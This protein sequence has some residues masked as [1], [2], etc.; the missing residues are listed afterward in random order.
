MGVHRITT[1]DI[2]HMKSEEEILKEA[3]N[4][5][6]IPT[7]KIV[8]TESVEETPFTIIQQEEEGEHDIL[9]G[10]YRMASFNTH[11]EAYEWCKKMTWTQIMQVMQALI[12]ENEWN[13][14]NIGA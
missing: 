9:M 1:N 3:R 5:E 4:V 11:T 6:E 2:K 12:Q 8:Y 10:V 14:N 7:N 13:K